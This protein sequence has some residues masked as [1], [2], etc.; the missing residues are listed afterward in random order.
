MTG[1]DQPMTLD[2]KNDVLR[3]LVSGSNDIARDIRKRQGESVDRMERFIEIQIGIKAE[4]MAMG[5]RHEQWM[6]D[7]E[8]RRVDHEKWMRD[9]EERM[10]EMS[11][12]HRM[13][14]RLLIPLA[15]KLGIMDDDGNLTD[16]Q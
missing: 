5:K 3:E 16:S 13:N 12:E 10:D 6:N 15:Q 8:Q 14:M 7:Q 11:R 4:L 2:E 9:H 1:N